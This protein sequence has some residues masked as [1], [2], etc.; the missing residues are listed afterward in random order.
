MKAKDQNCI[1]VGANSMLASRVV[2]EK[3]GARLR[4][5]SRSFIGLGL[6]SIAESVDIGDDVMMIS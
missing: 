6:M 1:E 5:G 4:V 3:S 2:Y